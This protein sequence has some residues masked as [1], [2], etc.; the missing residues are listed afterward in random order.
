MDNTLLLFGGLGLVTFFAGFGGLLSLAF[1]RVVSTNEVHIVQSSKHTISYGKDTGNGN[2]YY[3]WPSSLPFLGVSVTQLP[4]SVFVLDLEDYEAYDQGRLPFVIDVKAF[5]RISDSNIAAQRVANFQELN[6]QLR[7][8]VQGAIRAILASNDIETILQGRSTFGEQFT[9]EVETQL[10][11]W[12]V[13]AV[14][15]IELMDIRDHKDSQVIA[16][17]MAKKKSHIE[18]ESRTEVAK[19]MKNA[20]MAEIDATK[21]VELQTQEAAQAIGLRK[22]QVARQVSIAEQEARQLIKEQEKLTKEKEM[23][24]AQVE[25]VRTAE[26][27]KQ[28]Y[29]VQAEQNKQ[30]QILAAEG[31]LEFKKRE[32]EG[33]TLEGNAKANAQK[34]ML[35][36]P[37][38]AQTTLAK[39]I[40]SNDAYQKYLIGVEQ[41]KANQ[42]VGVAQAEALKAANIKVIAN[43]GNVS[44]GINNLTD[45][46]S[47]KGGTEVGAFLEGFA[48]TET[49]EKLLA[50]VIPA[51]SKTTQLSNGKTN[52]NGKAQ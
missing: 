4:V 1:R 30:T 27:E 50:K 48:N 18:M 13:A 47:S 22:T 39:E 34:A 16:N 35:L 3:Q 9:K 20:K 5:F 8:I 42:A 51:T 25:H 32:A 6:N 28:V 43:S 38:E 23:A 19:N 45:L 11:N 33:I 7:A 44:S 41:I 12:G 52:L 49:G 15:N 21:E 40:G 26:I 31:Q 17:I 37:V 46:I 14:K 29:L 36:A 2:I 10:Q 24:V